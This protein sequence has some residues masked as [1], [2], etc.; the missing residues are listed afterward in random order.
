MQQDTI[1]PATTT[2]KYSLRADHIVDKIFHMKSAVYH[3]RLE[4]FQTE[5]I[6]F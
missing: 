2:A 3:H 5:A 1:A 4:T 6:Y